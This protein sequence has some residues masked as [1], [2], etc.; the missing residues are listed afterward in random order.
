MPKTYMDEATDDLVAEEKLYQVSAP[1]L[2]G[3]IIVNDHDRVI[4]AAP[5][6]YYM[7]GWDL[8]RVQKYITNKG[9]G[10]VAC[11]QNAPLDYSDVCFTNQPA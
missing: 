8:P 1:H 5:I 4:N 2:V 3:G 6:L 9:W 10:L 7:I 11:K